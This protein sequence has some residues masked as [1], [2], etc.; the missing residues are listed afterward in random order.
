MVNWCILTPRQCL[1]GSFFTSVSDTL[2]FRAYYAI[3][4]L[5]LSIGKHI[6]QPSISFFC[7]LQIKG[8]AVRLLLIESQWTF[9]RKTLLKNNTFQ[10]V[11][12]LL[13]I[14]PASSSFLKLIFKVIS[15]D[16][17][18]SLIPLMHFLLK[19]D[20]CIAITNPI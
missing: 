9:Q 16:D 2:P 12:I 8:F 17:L 14:S 18:S 10:I 7:F 5:S 1:V 11:L 4:H 20:D 19:L 15:C 6:K 13:N 3:D